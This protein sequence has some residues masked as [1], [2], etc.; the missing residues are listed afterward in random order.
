LERLLS[1]RESAATLRRVEGLLQK[2]RLPSPSSDYHLP[3][4]LI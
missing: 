3:W 4:P 2:R 1:Q